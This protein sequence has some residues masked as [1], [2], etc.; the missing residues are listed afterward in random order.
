MEKVVL[1]YGDLHKGDLGL[2]P[3][4]RR[5]LIENVNI[6]IHNA[7]MVRYDVKPSYL[8]RINVI[9]TEKLLQLATEC[10]HLE[11]FAYVSTAY[12]HPS[13][14]IKEE[15][16]YP[17]PADIKLIEDVIK[18][19]EE[20]EAGITNEAMRDITGDWLDLYPFSKAT[21]EGLVESYGRK[22]S[23]PCI[24]YRP[25]IGIIIMIFTLRHKSIRNFMS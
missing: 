2:S 6:I 14:I 25:S 17:P 9:G 22:R 1:I 7:A 5:C 8:L 20:N 16:F 15:K 23:L 3:E 24:V 4:N 18:A 21:A 11:I 19:D 13:N 12:S 10:P